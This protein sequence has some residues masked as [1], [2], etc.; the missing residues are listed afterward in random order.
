MGN[1]WFQFKQFKIEQGRTAQKLST[2]A[3]LLGAM[4]HHPSPLKALD[5]GTGCGILALM[6]AQRFPHLQVFA[7]EPDQGSA[8][9]AEL[10]FAQAPWSHRLQLFQQNLASWLNA[11][12]EP[13]DLIVANPPYFKN[14]LRASIPSKN[15]ARHQDTLTFEHLML[16]ISQLLKPNGVAWTIYPAFNQADAASIANSFLLFPK[17]IYW[18]KTKKG[19]GAHVAITSWTFKP[20]TPISFEWDLLDVNGQYTQE[21]AQLLAPF[22]LK[23]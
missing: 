17:E 2:D 8:A 9:D 23:L 12:K 4:A 20:Q 5:I 6:L 7:I 21:I 18:I 1:N 19:A 15:N 22:Y 11:N 16:G 14:H 10:N 3:C 13:F